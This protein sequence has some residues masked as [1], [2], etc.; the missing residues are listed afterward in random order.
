MKNI[1]L[2]M[3]SGNITREPE[4]RS[5]A[6][7]DILNFSVACNDSKKTESGWEDVPNFI[8]CSLFGSRATALQNKLS[9]GTK[10]ALSGKL[11]WSQW[12]K[13]GEKRSKLKV[14]VDEL[15]IMSKAERN[16]PDV[17]FYVDDE[18]IPF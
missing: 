6:K 9:K 10:V 2:V 12:E 11:S 17:K 1:N 16:E 8:D 5:T 18:D 3:I 14:I 13:D 15:E 4:L 7:C